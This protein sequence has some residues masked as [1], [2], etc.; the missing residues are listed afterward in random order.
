MKLV[1]DEKLIS[2]LLL[3]G[4]IGIVVTL[5]VALGFFFIRQDIEEYQSS[6]KSLEAAQLR[7]EQERL[8][9]QV[10]TAKSYLT[11]MRSRTET[12]LKN[13]I[14][15]Q[16][17]EA[18]QLAETIYRREQGKRP[19]AE[20]KSLIVEALRNLRFFD[21]RGYF[22]IDG[23]DGTCILL[24]TAPEREGS[25]LLD[26]RDDTGHYIMRGLIS[27]ARLP[28]G[29]G[30]SRY[31]WY[32]PGD[33]KHMADKIA[34]VRL[35]KPFDW[36]IGTGEYVSNVEATLQRDALDRMSTFRFAHDGYVVILTEN[37]TILTNPLAQNDQGKRI[38]DLPD[39]ER[40][41]SET[42]LTKARQG[43]G[44]VS[45]N[46]RRPGGNEAIPK[47]SF[48]SRMDDWGW[49][50]VA[51]TYLDDIQK[52]AARHHSELDQ[53]VRD[54]VTLTLA[55]L[56][57]G[58]LAS[59]FVCLFF[60]TLLRR[61]IGGYKNDLNRQNDELRKATRDLFLVN[62]LVD[63]SAEMIFLT[64]QDWK[65]IYANTYVFESLGW[66]RGEMIGKPMTDFTTPQG[67]WTGMEYS[68]FEA[69][70]RA[71]DGSLREVEI[72]SK[73]LRYDG[74]LYHFAIARDITERKRWEIDLARKTTDLQRSNA[75]L[76]AFA[77]VA[78]HDLRQP[79]RMVSS[80]LTL[81]ERRLEGTLDDEA[82]EYLNF[83]RDGAHRMDR[84][85]IDLLEYSRVG[86]VNK[87]M[88]EVPLSD[89]MDD[90][91][92]NLRL[93]ISDNG[94]TVTIPDDLPTV[95]GNSDE[96][97]RLLQNLI[98]NALKYRGE[99]APVIKITCGQDA[100]GW[101]FAVQDNGIGI[102]PEFHQKIFG[103]FQ[104]LHSGDKYEG[105]GIGLAVCRK[106]I[107]RHG[108]KLW[109][110]SDGGNG[111]TFLFTLPFLDDAQKAY[112]DDGTT[113]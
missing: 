82:S 9:D 95:W 66:S 65:L 72:G 4:S 112:Q 43:D 106:I 44:F 2:R 16:V 110:E 41:I 17:D 3:A 107:E 21:G 81:L 54:K 57:L 64:D 80:F 67:D 78:S 26:N 51:G 56:A 23:M 105:T 104:R 31:R 94:A 49:V 45:Y 37:G 27:A 42:I 5:V 52:E 92:A 20:I 102:A 25:S 71:K 91:M 22:F 39:T 33:D 36:V 111:S 35:F 109:V 24:P 75:E 77:Y 30:F 103:L 32:A 89:A 93:A 12:V 6:L 68:R 60:A 113:P 88:T 86:R 69:H 7:Q 90:A 100:S 87:G 1:F 76:E 63:H 14:R 84:L 61:L 79:L 70:L 38:S 8:I 19:D 53:K 46:W 34:Y 10:D 96:L 40:I 55:A 59:M 85:I 11:F 97:T 13:T 15:E 74:N 98:G 47:I 101:R 48:V 73:E 29:D 58:V 28:E 99:A 108:G 50:L 18:Y 62:F 83:A